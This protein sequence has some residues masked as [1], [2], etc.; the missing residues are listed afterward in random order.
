[1]KLL[2]ILLILKLYVR[3]DI[4]KYYFIMLLPFCLNCCDSNTNFNSV[5]EI[6]IP[7]GIPTEETKAE[8]ETQ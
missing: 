2:V 6:E 7:I 4:F 1:M 8:I 3:L 5:A